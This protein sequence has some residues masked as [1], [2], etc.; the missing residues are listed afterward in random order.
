MLT[1]TIKRQDRTQT[2]S[3][4]NV[5]RALPFQ[6][7]LPIQFW[8]ERLLTTTYLMTH[9]PIKLLKGH[10]PYNIIFQTQPS[11]DGL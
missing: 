7:H 10:S 11:Y 3:H 5:A 9:T 8:G 2:L 1:P 4:L 6:A